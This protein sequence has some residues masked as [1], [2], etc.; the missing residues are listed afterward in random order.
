MMIMYIVDQF[1]EKFYTTVVKMG[2]EANSFTDI[3]EFLKHF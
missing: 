1:D 3:T 2:Q